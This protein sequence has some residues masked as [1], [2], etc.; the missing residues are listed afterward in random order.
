MTRIFCLLL[1]FSFGIISCTK[2]PVDTHPVDKNNTLSYPATISDLSSFLTTGYSNF[3]KDFFL[4]GFDLLTKEFACSEHAACLAYNPEQDWD[5]LATNQLSV[6]NLY[7]GRLWKGLYTGVKNTN[8]FFERADFFVNTY[9]KPTELADVDHMRGQACFLRAFYYFN[10]E[11]FFG[12]SYITQAGGG[13]KMGVPIFTNLASTLEETHHP[14]KTAREVWD[15]II[16]DLKMSAQLLKGVQWDGNN[17]G[18]ATEWS[19]KALLGKAYV[20]TEDWADAKI[21]LKDV[22]DNSGKS[23]M[24]FEKYKDAFNAN[25]Q[26]EFNEES[27]FELNVER[28]TDGYGIFTGTPSTNLTTSAGLIWAPSILG[29]N[30]AENGS[31]NNELGYGN[32]FVHDKNLQRFGFNLPIFTLIKNPNAAATRVNPD[33]IM[34]P[35]YMQ[36]SIDLRTNKIVD[37]RLYVCALQP[38]VDS[39][40]NFDG[41]Q[42]VAVARCNNIG[43]QKQYQGWSFKKYTTIDKSMSAYNG[44]DGA[45]I[46]F[47]RLADVYLLY[48][49]ACMNSGDNTNALEYINKVHRRAYSVPVD[50]TS[51]YDYASLT[52]P[53]KAAAEDVNLAN[54]PL[55][56]ERHAEL[57]AEGHWWFDV[58]RWHIG[59]NEAAYY[60]TGISDGTTIKWNDDRSYSYPIPGDEISS[61][62]EIANHQNPGY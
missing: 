22:I 61:N 30:G 54:N 25:P 12:E 3:R 16:S 53:T 13:E 27:L 15:L 31:G 38:W 62:P 52:S 7:A 37:P 20:F 47:L 40:G 39:C 19:A 24:P 29:Y 23:L 35:A 58:C 11:C 34:D 56:F 2:D 42:R 44:C 32:I 28:V 50:A 21:V 55:R 60:G 1:F 14:R 26:N 41:S 46:Y 49:E 43:N 8:V 5:E 9:A 45:N 18:R 57:F 17:L 4:Y 36:Q 33:S 48:A 6:Y 10:L 51:V 59:A